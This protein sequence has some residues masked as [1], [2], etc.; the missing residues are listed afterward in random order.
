MTIEPV[1]SDATDEQ[2]AA[3][4]EENLFALFRAMAGALGGE[5][6]E[7]EGLSHHLAFPTNPMYKGAWRTRLSAAD[8]DEA[9]DHTVTWFKERG[10]PFFFWWTGPSTQPADLGLRLAAHGLIDMAEQAEQLALGI[11]S[12]ALGAPCMVA[13]LRQMNETVL[14]RVPPGF[15]LEVVQDEAGLAGFKQVLIEGYDIP[16]QVADGWAQAAMRLGIGNT[17][18]RMYL[19]R[20]DGE[21][22]AT[23][24]LFNGG[25]AAGIFGV[26]TTPAARGKG[27]GAAISLHPLLE[28][29]EMG[30]RYG[31]LF[32][33]DMAVRV[34][35]R[36]GFRQT[37]Q[38]LNRYLWRNA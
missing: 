18:W 24:M 9:I 8:A 16:P 14:S 37:G 21:P 27:I 3:A 29:R 31:A 7:G 25:G 22:V 6:V 34:Y 13:D 1:L 19:G 2:L 30:Y 23:N 36:I 12:T 32:A 38:R 26:A 33:T 10:A 4:V 17:P 15:T 35:E 20:L 5:I 28:A 11:H